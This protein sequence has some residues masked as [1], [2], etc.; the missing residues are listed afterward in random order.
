MTSD[1]IFNAR[2]KVRI[3]DI[4]YGG[5]M[6]NDKFLLLFHDARMEFLQSLGLAES[7]LGDGVGLIMSEAHVN[8]KAEV[9]LGDE[10][11]VWVQVCDLQAVRF[12]MEY[13]VERVKDAVIVATGYTQM[14]AFDYQR[15][16][17]CKL[18]LGFRDKV[19]GK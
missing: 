18:P 16:R 13:E 10:L 3:G 14:A 17:I 8:Y 4:N 9:F 19:T 12:K 2:F 11:K 15:R 6:G 7:N 5:H 1:N